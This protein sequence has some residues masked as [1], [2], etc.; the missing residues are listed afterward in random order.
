[1]EKC[2]V[3]QKEQLRNFLIKSGYETKYVNGWLMMKCPFHQ[4]N[5][6]SFGINEITGNFNCFA[7]GAH[8][9]FNDF[10]SFLKIDGIMIDELDIPSMDK[11]DRVIKGL[12]ENKNV[13]TKYF[14]YFVSISENDRN[15]RIILKY[16][17]KR[18]IKYETALKYNVGYINH[19]DYNFRIVFPVYFGNKIIWYEGRTLKDNIKPKWWRPPFIK[20]SKYR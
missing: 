16:I 6:P 4:E 5:I 14:K 10:L 12:K 8:G 15:T 17:E 2:F 20:S 18:H 13:S 3:F 9:K 19:I 7:C 1:M 11:Y